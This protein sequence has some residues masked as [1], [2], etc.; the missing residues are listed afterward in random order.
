MTVYIIYSRSIQRFYIGYTS[1]RIE[2]RLRRHN[3]NHTGYTGKASDWTIVYTEEV[4]DKKEALRLETKIKGRGA[5]RYLESKGK[6]N[7]ARKAE[8]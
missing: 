6:S 3:S 5:Q 8:P 7:F 1:E 4:L 2:D